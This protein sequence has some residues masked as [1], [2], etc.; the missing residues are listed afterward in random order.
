MTGLD[1]RKIATYLSAVFLAGA[2]AG[3]AGG[4]QWGRRFVFRPP[5]RPRDMLQKLTTDYQLTPD[6]VGKIEP[7]V[8][9]VNQRMRQIQ[10]EQFKQVGALMNECNTR[11]SEHLD[12]RQK[13]KLIENE[14]RRRERWKRD[15]SHP[16]DAKEASPTNSVP[17]SAS[18]APGASSDAPAPSGSGPH[19]P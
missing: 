8:T 11:I 13:Q 2:A 18:P 4:Y 15:H 6:Q 5:P 16:P 9:D 10:R 3:L 1:R 7:I 17:P 19:K 12:E 14:T